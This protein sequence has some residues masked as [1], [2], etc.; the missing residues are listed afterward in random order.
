MNA[1]LLIVALSSIAALAGC[2]EYGG[3]K[4]IGTWQSVKHADWKHVITKEGDVF[5]I[6]SILGRDDKFTMKGDRLCADLNVGACYD[7][8]KDDDSIIDYDGQKWTRV[9]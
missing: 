6:K 1:K 9:K 4:F 2:G 7:Y 5:L 8:Q 3:D